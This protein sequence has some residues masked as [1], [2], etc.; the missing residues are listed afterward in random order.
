MRKLRLDWQGYFAVDDKTIKG[1]VED[2]AGVFKLSMPQKDGT[3]KPILTGQAASVRTRLVD[4]VN[5]GG[6]PEIKEQIKKGGCQFRFAYLYTKEDL[7]AAERALY[8]RYTPKLND[9]SAVP[10]AEDVEVNVN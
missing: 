9:K 2:R 1:K 8:K 10:E 7:D 5:S 4:F 6:Y 3:L